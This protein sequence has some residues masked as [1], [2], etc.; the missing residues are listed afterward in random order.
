M[1]LFVS[2]LLA[3]HCRLVNRNETTNEFLKD[4]SKD[5]N[6]K[7]TES[8]FCRSL[9]LRVLCRGR[10]PSLI[11]NDLIRVSLLLESLI[12]AESLS[13]SVGGTPRPVSKDAHFTVQ[14][15]MSAKVKTI[16][17]RRKAQISICSSSK[18]SISID[19]SSMLLSMQ[20]MR[21][22]EDGSVE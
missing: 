1:L 12:D 8:H 4:R 10:K 13:Q 5:R 9:F 17:T 18:Q 21:Q 6:Y 15:N 19:E 20:K 14:D 3:F 11:T 22:K 16:Q 2:F 7:F